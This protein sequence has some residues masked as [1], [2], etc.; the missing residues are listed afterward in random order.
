MLDVCLSEATMPGTPWTAKERKAL[1]RQILREKKTPAQVEIDGRSVNAVRAQAARMDLIPKRASRAKWSQR[2]LDLLQDLQQQGLT[3]QQIYDGSLLGEPVRTKW[4][5]T[6]QWGRMHLA[7]QRRVDLMKQKKRWA[8][9]E[10]GKFHAYLLK[11]S[12]SKTPE[13]IARHWS[14][15]RSTV[16]RWQNALGVKATRDE[17]L[18]MRYSREKQRRALKRIQEASRRMWK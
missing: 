8:N 13:E 18:Q 15:A 17:V 2:Q 4:A 3:P 9:G 14:V 16:S 5:I 6:K 1:R 7:D 10:L 12:S 11:H